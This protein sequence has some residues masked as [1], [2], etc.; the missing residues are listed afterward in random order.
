M[1]QYRSL[2]VSPKKVIFLIIGTDSQTPI[3]RT[4]SVQQIQRETYFSISVT[5]TANNGSLYV[6]LNT[7]NSYSLQLEPNKKQDSFQFFI[8]VYEERHEVLVRVFGKCDTDDTANLCMYG[9]EGKYAT[10]K[11]DIKQGIESVSSE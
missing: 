5:L 1:V 10:V 7:N 6:A 2:N 9:D 11:C 8:P 4:L 3:L